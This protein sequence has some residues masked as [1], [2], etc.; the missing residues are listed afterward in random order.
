MSHDRLHR[1]TSLLPRS[2]LGLIIPTPQP[3]PRPRPRALP[4]L[5]LNKDDCTACGLCVEACQV[6]AISVNETAEIDKELCIMC[7]ACVMACPEGA[8]SLKPR[9]A[10]A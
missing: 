10:P 9:Q 5:L 2:P 4:E 3:R 7:C 8:L 6:D 1:L